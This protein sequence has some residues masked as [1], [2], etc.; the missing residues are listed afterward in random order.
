M[1][2]MSFYLNFC[3]GGVPSEVEL[4]ELA[5]K[6]PECWYPLGIQLCLD[7][8]AL[9]NIHLNNIEHTS[10]AKKAFQML[11]TWRNSGMCATYGELSEAL[12]KVDRHDLADRISTQ[13]VNE[14]NLRHY[15]I[16]LEN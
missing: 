14:T 5:K 2:H 6:I 16:A 15:C 12:R 7:R 9:D 13:Q 10:P 11:V 3:A 4:N 1:H 8:A